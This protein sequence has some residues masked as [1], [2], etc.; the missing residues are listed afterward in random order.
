[1]S[2]NELVRIRRGDAGQESQGNTDM[3]KHFQIEDSGAGFTLIELMVVVSMIALLLGFSVPLVFKIDELSRDRSGVN[4]M[5]VAVTAARAYATRPIADLDSV[6][7]AEYSGAA[8]LVTPFN[9]LRII[10]DLQDSTLEASGLSAFGYDNQTSR[11]EPITVPRGVGIAGIVRTAAGAAGLTLLPPPFVLR[12]DRHGQL[13]TEARTAVG[14][15]V[16]IRRNVVYYDS[17]LND[18][19]NVA[20]VRP[21]GYTPSSTDPAQNYDPDAGAISSQWNAGKSDWKMAF[22]AL[23][24]VIGVVVYSKADFEDAGGK[25]PAT[26]PVLGCSPPGCGTGVAGVNKWM[27]ENGTPLFFSRYTGNILRTK[28]Q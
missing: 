21:A 19:F 9:Q 16:D 6:P 24:A 12:F 27:F 11:M 10:S 4:T 3:N 17:D 22:E 18:A 8:I 5:G 15:S 13:V 14:G 1:M 7:T 20:S 2:W 23:E 25:W 26:A 28:R